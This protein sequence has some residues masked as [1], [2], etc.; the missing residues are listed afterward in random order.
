LSTACPGI[1][2][3]KICIEAIGCHRFAFGIRNDM[4]PLQKKLNFI[5]MVLTIVAILLVIWFSHRVLI[6]I[7][8]EVLGVMLVEPCLH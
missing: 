5:L 3:L 1:V 7:E 4:K 6:Q 8:Q 2:S